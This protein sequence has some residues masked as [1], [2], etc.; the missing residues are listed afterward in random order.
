MDSMKWL[1]AV[2][3]FYSETILLAIAPLCE[4]WYGLH[5]TA[6]IYEQIIQSWNLISTT[7][8]FQYVISTCIRNYLP[9][10][11]IEVPLYMQ[12]PLLDFAQPNGI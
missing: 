6:N 12:Q 10:E 8:N 4:I 9:I 3:N 1:A 11:L 2:W 7:R 5:A